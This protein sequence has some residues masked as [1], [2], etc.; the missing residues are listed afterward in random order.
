MSMS[1]HCKY[2]E[3][4]HNAT[5]DDYK[6]LN[7]AVRIRPKSLHEGNNYQTGI[8]TAGADHF[9]QHCTTRGIEKPVLLLKVTEKTLK[10][11]YLT[12]KPNSKSI[13]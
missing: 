6:I 10:A 11:K 13:L 7:D 1:V 5:T 2:N 12:H 8:R 9:F 3:L 4:T